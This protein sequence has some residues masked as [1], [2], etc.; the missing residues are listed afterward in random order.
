LEPWRESS[1]TTLLISGDPQTLR[2][3]AEVV[4]G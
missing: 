2:T 3:A 1:V 4:L